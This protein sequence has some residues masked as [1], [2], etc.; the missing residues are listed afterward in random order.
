MSL[1]NDGCSSV[2]AAGCWQDRLVHRRSVVPDTNIWRYVVDEGAVED[3]RKAA[4]AAEVDIVACPAVLYE[5]LRIP[6]PRLRDELAKA[7]TRQAWLRPMPEA[8]L[9]AEDLRSEIQR[10]RSRWMVAAPNLGYWWKLQSDWQ[11][12]TWR[13]ARSRTGFMARAIDDRRPDD[14]GRA[15]AQAS[16][17]RARAQ[18][19]GHTI[20]T[21]KLDQATAWYL[22]EVPGWD[23]EK[24]E[25]WRAEGEARWW[26]DL[27]GD[28]TPTMDEWLGPWLDLGYIRTHRSEWT[29]FWTREVQR[30]R[31]PREWV[32]WAMGAVQ[33][34]K[35]VTPGT[36]VDN[37]IA[38]YLTD[39]ETFVTADR[40]FA[41]CVETMRPYAPC[42]L[43]STAVVP[44]GVAAVDGLLKVVARSGSP[45]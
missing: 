23:G 24:F 17:S 44:A 39:F 4:R 1:T 7:L 38:T 32:R 16:V 2:K 35:K 40:G 45:R 13:R 20:A 28:P 10:A 26:R 43:A 34:L 9:E 18:E 11:Q 21:L 42:A 31:L 3:V 33:A 15:R 5:C 36:P 19:L 14:L 22:E 25:S 41:D 30:E 37:Q 12:G 6:K 29:S 27:I 8:F